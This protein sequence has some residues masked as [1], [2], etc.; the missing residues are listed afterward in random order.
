[1]YVNLHSHSSFSLLDGITN[2]D[3]LA[4]RAKK[5][6]MPATAITDH[7]NI[8]GWPDFYLACKECG[9]KPI[10][11]VEAY[12]VPDR[13]ARQTFRS[14]TG[15]EV[16]TG[17][18][19]ILLAKNLQG[20]RNIIALNNEAH[21]N[22]FYYSPKI[23]WETLLK[24][25]DGLIVSSACVAG[26]IGQICLSP[27]DPKPLIDKFR[28]IWGEDYYLELMD[29]GMASDVQRT[30]LKR[31]IGAAKSMGVKAIPTNDNHYLD[32]E[33]Q[34]M[35]DMAMCMHSKKTLSDPKRLKYDGLYHM[36]S[37][38]EMAKLFGE[39]MM[40]TMEIAE[41]VENYEIFDRAIKLPVLVPE[42]DKILR[43]MAVGGLSTR[44]VTTQPYVDRLNFELGIIEKKGFAAYLL[45]IKEVID[46][47]DTHGCPIG[48]GRGSAG[49]SLL[50]Y[51]LGITEVDPLKYDLLFERFI[52]EARPDW[53][54]I[55]VDISR[56][57]RDSIIAA[58]IQRYGADKVAHI[59]TFHYM[60]P[61]ILIR[62]VCRAAEKPT[63][64]ADA[65]SK[66]VP[67][68]AKDYEDLK[69]T[70]LERQL[71]TGVD[72]RAILECLKGL[73]GIPRHVGTHASG[74][75]ISPVPIVE[76]LPVKMDEGKHVIQYSM[77][78]IDKFGF[79]KFDLLGLET[80]DLVFET[81]AEVGIDIKKIP[82]DDA[83]T[84]QMIGDGKVAGLFQ[85]DKSKTCM[86]ICKRIKPK[87]IRD[88]ADIIAL[89]RPGVLDAGLLEVYLRRR[90][91]IDQ[92]TY[93]HDDLKV[94]LGPSFGVCIY[95]EDLMRMAAVYAGYT[96]AE[97]E[98]LR[99]GIGKKD[100]SIIDKHLVIFKEKALALGRNPE[101][102]D[103]VLEQVKAAGNYSF[104][105]CHAHAYSMLTYACGY[106]AANYP[107]HFF[108]NLINHAGEDDRTEYLSEVLLRQFVI[109]PPNI[110]TSLKEMSVEGESI[111]MGLLHIKSVGEVS[112]AKIMAARPYNVLKDVT[113]KLG[114][115]TV[116]TLYWAHALDGLPDIAEYHPIGKI[117][118]VDLLGIPLH[119]LLAEFNDVVDFIQATSVATI[120]ESGTCVIKITNIHKHKDRNGKWMAFCEGWD[121][122]GPQVK[123]L[124]MFASIH[125]DYGVDLKV[126]GVYGMVLS[127]LANG[128]YSIKALNT[129]AKIRGK[130][131][132][133][134]TGG[135]DKASSA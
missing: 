48:W 115:S 106:L 101:E 15:K 2:P 78:H 33:E 111:R 123:P 58:I 45:T 72:G 41:K 105:K 70:D 22:G 17:Y 90:D 64:M 128:G 39:Y 34:R 55:D 117:D 129:V 66:M 40:N 5:L 7:G 124:I 46:L 53:P 54:D 12:M 31:V 36:K 85:L 84:Y 89:N 98:N 133:A 103:T 26:E 121:V 134:K 93:L 9:V 91:G 112:A 21:L 110:N 87:N 116:A 92:A 25:K 82:L 125:E 20:Y 60:K 132:A 71:S 99:K 61:K 30:I 14:A 6:G 80:L 49:G 27:Q 1:M 38:P 23:D 68:D 32:A 74:I 73:L 119:G 69:G 94:I 120:V 47:I 76:H 18:H 100:T 62:D 104:N 77:E 97:V 57:K 108:K 28:S 44:G 50:C 11:G 109:L 102:V 122:H 79:L 13:H 10:L 59:S 42:P 135:V 24:H 96:S 65:L 19:L 52:S 8:S 126:G 3:K 29:N 75:V 114:K 130:I 56:D 43:M 81:A 83:K 67:K 63:A 35:H 88:L 107:L 51:A 113:T 95:Q 16:R 37:I 4:E 131:M 118:E 127:R 86:D